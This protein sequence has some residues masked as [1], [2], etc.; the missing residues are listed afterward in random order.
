MALQVSERNAA[1]GAGVA[2][3]L[4]VLTNIIGLDL[5]DQIVALANAL[6]EGDTGS[7]SFVSGM[8]FTA[9]GA[10]MILMAWIGPLNG[11]NG[12]ISMGV[13]MGMFGLGAESLNVGG[14]N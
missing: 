12:I 4:P 13:G 9:I 2:A 6:F 7:A 8:G 1:I 10:V 14:G 3:G 5:E 11:T